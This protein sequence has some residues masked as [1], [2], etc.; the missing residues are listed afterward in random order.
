MVRSAAKKERYAELDALR[1]FALFGILLANLY[2]FIGYNTYSPNEIVL[3]P[4]SDRTVLFFIDWFVEGKFYSIFSMLFGMGFA[5]QSMRMNDNKGIFVNYW[6]RR[7]QFLLLI[8]LTHLLFIWNGDILTLYSL[9]GFLLVFFLNV[10]Q[11][12]LLN[13]SIMLLSFPLLMHVI[14]TIMQDSTFWTLLSDASNNW[15]QSLGYGELSLLEMR[16]SDNFSEVFYIN[17]LKAIERPMGYFMTGRPAGV[18]GMFVLGIYLMK[19]WK[20][21]EDKAFLVKWRL[22]FVSGLLLSLGYAWTKLVSGTPYA[23]DR[24][25]MLQAFIYHTSAPIFAVGLVGGFFYIWANKNVQRVMKFFLPLGRMALTNYIIQTSLSV[26]L[27]FGYGF[28]LMREIPFSYIPFIA[29]S[30]LMAQWLFS[31]YW[32]SRFAQGPLELP[33]RKYAYRNS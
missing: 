26:T 16:T 19:S 2:S 21:N 30:I 9:M 15:Q 6:L 25:G 23:L 5:L 14:V 17:I 4:N 7:M 28:A 24:F 8:G 22:F 32:L 10:S 18:L 20:H 1:G 33:W 13:I 11:P 12:A 3:L 29:F 27:F 31:K